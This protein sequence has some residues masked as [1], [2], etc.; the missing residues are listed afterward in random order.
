MFQ[1]GDRINW[2]LFAKLGLYRAD[3]GGKF[4]LQ[5]EHFQHLKLISYAGVINKTPAF[6]NLHTTPYSAIKNSNNYQEEGRRNKALV[7]GYLLFVNR[8]GLPIP[9]SQFPIPNSQFPIPNSQFP[10]L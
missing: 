10:T 6:N 1:L 5:G 8:L 3:R 4:L 7:S 2:L 9:N